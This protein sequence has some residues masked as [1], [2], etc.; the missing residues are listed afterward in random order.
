MLAG[1]GAISMVGRRGA[2]LLGVRL[3]LVGVRYWRARVQWRLV[4]VPRAGGY[5]CYDG[6]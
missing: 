2:A 4:G 5:G 1:R 6:W 3:W